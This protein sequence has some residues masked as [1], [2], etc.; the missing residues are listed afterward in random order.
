MVCIT[1]STDQLLIS[2]KHV[3]QKLISL[4]IICIV[5]ISVYADMYLEKSHDDMYVHVQYPYIAV[6]LD[7]YV[8]LMELQLKLC[9]H[10]GVAY[11]CENAHLLSYRSE[12]T[13][14]LLFIII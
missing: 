14:N 4:Y 12:H 2:L 10:S 8:P 9:I 7:W 1:N 5:H 13:C 11:D 3:S 6:V